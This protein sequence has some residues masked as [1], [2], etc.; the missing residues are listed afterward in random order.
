M[1]FLNR[2][3][4]LVALCALMVVSVSLAVAW[5]QG[6]LPVADAAQSGVTVLKNEKATVDASNLVRGFVTVSYTGGKNV[7]IKVQITK[8]GGEAYSYNLNNAGNPETFPLTEGN[9]QYTVTVFENTT[10]G[11]YAQ[12][13]STKLDVKLRDPL[14][15]FLYPN[16]YVNFNAKSNVVAKAEELCKGKNSSLEKVE[17]VY[18]YIVKNFTYDRERAATVKSGYLP[19]VDDVLAAKKGI[20]FDYSAV[21]S[22]MLRS[23]GIPCKLVVGYTGKTYHAWINVYI[24]GQGWIEQYIFFDGTNWTMMDPTFVSSG[25][26]SDSIKKYVTTAGNYVQKYAY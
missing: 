11:K 22:S 25:K 23:Q 18:S 26:G 14:L 6:G 8:S 21:M 1:K 15:P 24:E 5:A 4:F 10:N 3:V 16:Q 9:G 20:C 19:V 7:K 13:Y 2:K 12:A 17:A